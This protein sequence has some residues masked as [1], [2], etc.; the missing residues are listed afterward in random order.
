LRKKLSEMGIDPVTHKPFSQI[1]ADYGNIGGFRKPG[2]RIGSLNKDFKSAIMLKSEPYPAAP[3][4]LPNINTQLMSKTISPQNEPFQ[5]TL[6]NY[7]YTDNH[8]MDLLAELQS[9]K[10]VTEASNCTKNNETNI[11]PPVFAEA[12]LSSS[13]I[14]YSPTC[15]TTAVQE[16]S[17]LDFSWHDF[18]L[19]DAFLQADPQEQET[20]TEYSSKEFT[21]QKQKVIL[22]SDT[23]NE[24]AIQESSIKAKGIECA[25]VCNDFEASSSSDIAFVE[26]M[27]YQ[28]YEMLL[29]F[30]NLE[31]FYY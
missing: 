27:L 17:P 5:D 3:Q 28:E 1:L 20:M 6:L 24:A 16:K 11:P 26:A 12:S 2:T 7:N 25:A 8:P 13:S 30:P 14:S 15:S 4:G 21:S 9:I 23:N 18:L 22:E 31:P 10:L 29:D 19:D